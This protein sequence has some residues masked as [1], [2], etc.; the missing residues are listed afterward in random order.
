MEEAFAML[1]N[2]RKG[3]I[4]KIQEG[5]ALLEITVPVS[6]WTC[7]C[8]FEHRHGQIY[9][10]NKQNSF[11]SSNYFSIF[12]LEN[13]TTNRV[14]SGNSVPQAVGDSPGSAQNMASDT[15]GLLTH[16]GPGYLSDNPPSP[17][18]TASQKCFVQIKGMTCASCVSNIE[19][20]LQRQAGK[21][22]AALVSLEL[23]CISSSSTVFNSLEQAHCT[24]LSMFV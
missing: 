2:W 20:S 1:V 17:G 13:I 22:P 6:L 7:Q 12:I 3:L 18:G 9:C 16:Q 21:R 24:I 19:R 14:S 15:R 4:W 10:C 5:E 8:Q 11:L 23:L